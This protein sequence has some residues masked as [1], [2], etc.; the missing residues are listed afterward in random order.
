V[1]VEQLFA[2]L[3][4]K[5]VFL[6]AALANVDYCE[7]NSEA[8]YRVN[9]AG[10]ANVVRTAQQIG[11]KLVYF[12]SDYIFNG[13]AG[14][15]RED[16]PANPICVYGFHKMM[17]EHYVASQ[18]KNYLIIRTTVVY[19]WER[20][21]K[22]FLYRLAN[23]LGSG[24]QLYVPLDQVGSPTYAP[25]LAQVVLTLAASE[26][27]GVFN[28]VGPD[29]VDRYEFACEAARV[30]GMDVDGIV[31][32]RTCDLRQTARR[33][34]DAGMCIDKVL[35]TTKSELAGYREGLRLMEPILRKHLAELQH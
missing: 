7:T 17:A 12:S 20:Q 16:D 28:V 10:C 26:A 32:V 25:N 23:V 1:Q 5:V 27:T 34:L 29:R 21:G 11:A 4:P 9:V 30:L 24:Q 22:N 2:Q 15:Y 13:I 8:S 6:P 14:P 3:R 35:H 18:M 33:P 19:G 31:P